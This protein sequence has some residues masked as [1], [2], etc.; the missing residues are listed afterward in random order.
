MQL[1]CK[2]DP[3]LVNLHQERFGSIPKITAAYMRALN[4]LSKPQKPSSF[5]RLVGVLC[6]RGFNSWPG[7]SPRNLWRFACLYFIRQITRQNVAVKT[8]RTKGRDSQVFF[9]HNNNKNGNCST[10]IRKPA[11]G[12]ALICLVMV[13]RDHLKD[14]PGSSAEE[15]MQYP[16]I[17]IN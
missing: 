3:V 17:D 11:I 15:I 9:P 16:K 2:N 13:L 4:T 7:R 10:I 14:C 12:K 8:I 5:L 6:S 1:S